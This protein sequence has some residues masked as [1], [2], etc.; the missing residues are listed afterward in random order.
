MLQ[1][2]Y[3]AL[4]PVIVYFHGGCYENGESIKGRG[5]T[6]WMDERVVIV[7]VSYRLGA[8]GKS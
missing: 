4:L 7:S 3:G 1:T 5:A 6:Y 8:L 2:K